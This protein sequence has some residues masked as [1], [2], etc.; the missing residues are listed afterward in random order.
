MSTGPAAEKAFKVIFIIAII[1][2]CVLVIG[3]F[4]LL[5]KIL[6]LFFP[7]IQLMGLAIS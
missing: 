3:I 2:F 4:L 7:E 6:L 1:L 5:I